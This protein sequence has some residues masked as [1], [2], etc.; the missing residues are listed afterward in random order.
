MCSGELAVG[1]GFVVGNCL[2]GEGVEEEK[3]DP[4]AGVMEGGHG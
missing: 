4:E 1:R 3:R 2:S